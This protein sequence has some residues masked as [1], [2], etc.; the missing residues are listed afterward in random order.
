MGGIV[1][2]V[3]NHAAVGGHDN[4]RWLEVLE[5]GRHSRH[6]NF[7]D[8]DWGVVDPALNGRVAVPFLGKPYG[9]ALADGE[10]ELAFDAQRGRLHVAYYDH[11]FPLA[12]QFYAA[13][14]R[15][16]GSALRPER[17]RVGKECGRKC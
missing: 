14:L 6:A 5:W 13:F 2:I 16:G 10:L 15:N 1:D 8:I 11:H 17:R 7:F 4:A 3:P 12:P 9:E